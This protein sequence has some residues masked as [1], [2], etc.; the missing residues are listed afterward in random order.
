MICSEA[1]LNTLNAFST[2]R[3]FIIPS[4]ISDSSSSNISAVKKHSAS[5]IANHSRTK[6][7]VGQHMTS[8]ARW[9]VGF[10]CD[11]RSMASARSKGYRAKS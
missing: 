2:I 1:D 4:K 10:S 7:R 9:K 8:R 11:M 6:V 5:S 3:V